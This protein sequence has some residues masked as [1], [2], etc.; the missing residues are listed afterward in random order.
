MEH[1]QITLGLSVLA[2]ILLFTVGARNNFSKSSARD[3]TIPP[4]F[5]D[6]KDSA[7]IN[8]KVPSDQMV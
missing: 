2:L 6:D 8:Q 5:F 4:V 1:Y 7:N 3:S